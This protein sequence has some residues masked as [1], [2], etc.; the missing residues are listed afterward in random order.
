MISDEAVAVAEHEGK[1]K[2]IEEEA[3]ET[4]VNNTFHQHVYGFARS[5][6]A[7]LEHGEAY[8]HAE[9]QE[10]SNQRPHRIDG[11]DDV[12]SL[13]S[14]FRREHSCAEQARAKCDD[15]QNQADA[16]R[17]PGK[18]EPS[19]APPLRISHSAGQAG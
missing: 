2:G 3:A 14:G 4:G 8:L 1:T 13:N 16:D 10:S 18:Q 19:V 9:Y 6:K 12:C 7:G 17:L 5:T 11:I 15:Q